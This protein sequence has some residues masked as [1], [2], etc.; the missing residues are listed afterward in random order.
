MT[1][2]NI[3]LSIPEKDKLSETDFLDCHRNIRIVLTHKKKLYVLDE[4]ILEEQP[5]GAPNAKRD[6]Y[7]KHLNDSVEVSCIIL[8]TMTPKL[9]KQN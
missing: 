9:Q 6:S 2:N 5:V 4:P 8:A 1:S 7:H 3:L